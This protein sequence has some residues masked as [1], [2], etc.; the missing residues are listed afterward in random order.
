MAE[1]T[2]GPRMGLAGV[3]IGLVLLAAVPQALV[4]LDEPTGDAAGKGMASAFQV[5]IAACIGVV[6]LE[7]VGAAIGLATVPR[8]AA[9][10]LGLTG[11]AWIG[12][13]IGFAVAVSMS[14]VPSYELPLDWLWWVWL[15]GFL[16]H[17]L[18]LGWSRGTL[19]VLGVAALLLLTLALFPA[20]YLFF[21]A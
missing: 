11:L 16:W 10:S 13:P 14:D 6:Q 17:G 21:G 8:P 1:Q 3:C 5:L 4:F 18:A 12:P 7:L 9:V 15:T 20:S 2:P 19:W